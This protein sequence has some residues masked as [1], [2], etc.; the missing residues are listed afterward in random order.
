MKRRVDSF[1]SLI[2]EG[3]NPHHYMHLENGEWIIYDDPPPVL[4]DEALWNRLKEA[5]A[6][7][8]AISTEIINSCVFEPLDPVEVEHGKQQWKL[9]QEDYNP[10][11]WDKVVDSLRRHMKNA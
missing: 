11:D 9:L 7:L 10:M 8:H 5:Q 2:D 4:R 1:S 6:A 3:L